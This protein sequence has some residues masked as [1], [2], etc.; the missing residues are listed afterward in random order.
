MDLLKSESKI[1]ADARFLPDIGFL[2]VLGV[3]FVLAIPR[4]AFFPAAY[5]T[6]V[7]RFM[8]VKLSA[9]IR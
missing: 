7:I 2:H 9:L 3:S 8:A 4:P 6:N 1:K 5:F